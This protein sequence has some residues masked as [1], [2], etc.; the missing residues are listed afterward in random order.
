MNAIIIPAIAMGALGLVLGL[1]LAFASK[2]FA[3][4]TDERITLVTEA[5][6]GANCGSCGFAGCSAYATA[7]VNDGAKINAC[8]PG[9]QAAA[10]KIAKIMGLD[11]VEVDE[12]RA[13]V[14]CSGTNENVKY[15]YNYIGENSCIAA[16]KLP[17]GGNKACEFACL[18]LG[19]CAEVCSHNA[20][21]IENNLAFINPDK[22]GGCGEC[23]EVCPKNIISIVS[24]KSKYVVKCKN[25]DK[26]A[27]VK[28]KCSL[29]CI[30]C[31]ICEKNCPAGAITVTNN[32][33]SIDYEKCTQCGLCAEKCPKRIIVSI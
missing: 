20:I 10:D 14:H 16:A 27:I 24:R 31:K 19:S 23:A 7:I 29:G 4:K 17:G 15:K 13:V 30:A 3:V 22:C 21:T 1:L 33:A 2:I 9:G 28:E 32:C 12:K 8:S 6:P 26:G 11:S 5:L 25:C 18:G